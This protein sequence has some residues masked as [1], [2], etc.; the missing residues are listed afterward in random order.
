MNYM[1]KIMN[2]SNDSFLIPAYQTEQ[3]EIGN[4]NIPKNLF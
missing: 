2:N 4:I 3:R 1:K